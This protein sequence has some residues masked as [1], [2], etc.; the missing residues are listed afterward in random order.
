MDSV[1]IAQGTDPLVADTD[2]DGFNDGID[3]FPL[4]T[5]EY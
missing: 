4:D 1:E 3:A 5:T 2:Q